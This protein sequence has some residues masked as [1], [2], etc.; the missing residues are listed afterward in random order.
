[1]L[2]FASTTTTTTSYYLL[3]YYKLIFL[4]AYEDEKSIDSDHS[5]TH[6]Y[7]YCTVSSTL[8]T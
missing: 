4:G 3:F 5:D 7:N 8:K 1:M 2:Y 6:T